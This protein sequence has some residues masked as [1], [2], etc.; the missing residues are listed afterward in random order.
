MVA[1]IKI[2]IKGN[3]IDIDPDCMADKAYEPHPLIKQLQPI[4]EQLPISLSVFWGYFLY[5]QR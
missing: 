2:N 3:A 4:L 5:R 1:A